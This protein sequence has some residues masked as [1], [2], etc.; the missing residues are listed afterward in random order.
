[1]TVWYNE[2]ILV[3][4]KKLNR[5]PSQHLL[6]QISGR[7][8]VSWLVSPHLH[9]ICC[10][11]FCEVVVKGTLKKIRIQNRLGMYWPNIE[12]EWIVSQ[13]YCMWSR[14]ISESANRCNQVLVHMTICMWKKKT[15]WEWAS[16]LSPPL[17]FCIP[18]YVVIFL[19][20][21]L[22]VLVSHPNL[23]GDNPMFLQLLPVQC[24]ISLLLGIFQCRL[25]KSMPP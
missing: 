8:P 6:I 12:R 19:F 15:H 1:M 11:S 14:I 24:A 7:S 23:E 13:S 21:L 9:S 17:R 3:Y 2:N 16:R 4:T 5:P 20:F 22:V 25:I 10:G 18:I